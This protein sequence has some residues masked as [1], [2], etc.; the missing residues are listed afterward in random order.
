MCPRLPLSISICAA[1]AL[2]CGCR[3]GVPIHVW[4]PPKLNSTVG[5]RVVLSTVAGPEDI[6]GPLKQS[7]LAMSPTDQGRTTTLVDATS[8]QTTPQI[9]LVSATEEIGGGP[10]AGAGEPN[11]VMLASAARRAGIDFVLRGE[12]LEDRY[13]NPQAEEDPDV[14]KVSWRLTSL[15]QADPVAAGSPIVVDIQS[16]QDRYPDLTLIGEP[17]ELLISAAARDAFRLITP[18]V[19]RD[20]VQLAI[21]YLMLGSRDVRRGNA[22]ALA[23]RWGDAE[24]IWSEALE[25]HPMQLAALHNMALAAAA[26]QDFSRAKL[27]A[28]KAIRRLPSAHYKQT[29]VWIEQQQRAYHKAFGLPDPPEGW[30]VTTH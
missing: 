11:D 14:L 3:M 22:A 10:V 5:K 26:G 9:K 16:A 21:P 29:L 13:K 27:L 4:Q 8:L 6:A 18:S 15:N 28:R 24:E 20:R 30:F 25:K 19:E 12:V 1:V 23:G 2:M 17:S 7:L